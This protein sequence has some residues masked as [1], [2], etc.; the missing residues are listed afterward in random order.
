MTTV[1]WLESLHVNRPNH[2][3]TVTTTEQNHGWRLNTSALVDAP[4]NATE[5]RQQRIDGF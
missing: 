3:P 1:N 2:E 4:A 5:G